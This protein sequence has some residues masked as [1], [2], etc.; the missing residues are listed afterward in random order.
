MVT[1]SSRDSNNI[2]HIRINLKIGFRGVLLCRRF[3]F[4]DYN[5]LIVR[6]DLK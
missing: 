6:P 5:I 4:R 2:K 3:S 1:G